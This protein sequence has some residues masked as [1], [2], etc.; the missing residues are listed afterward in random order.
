[1]LI[2]VIRCSN[3]K[4]SIRGNIIIMGREICM[5]NTNEKKIYRFIEQL[6]KIFS[7]LILALLGG[8][9][10]FFQSRVS[11]DGQTMEKVTFHNNSA[12][13][14]LFLVCII[15][16]LIFI[17]NRI[18]QLS[19][20][21]IYSVFAIIFVFFGIILALGVSTDLRADALEIYKS[22]KAF[23][24]GDFSALEQGNYVYHYPHQLGM[25]T[26]EWIMLKIVNNVEIL[27]LANLVF[28]LLNNY[29]LGQISGLLFDSQLAQNITLI[30]SF[31]F[32]PQFFFIVFAYGTIP[33]FSM[34]LLALYCQLRFLKEHRK[35]FF[36]LFIIF[37]CI[38]CLLK[39]N[40]L[41][42]VLAASAFF[43]FYA[44]KERKIRFIL[45]IIVTLSLVSL[46]GKILNWSY[47]N[48]SGQEVSGGEPK[49]LWIAMGLR[50]ESDKLGGWYDRYN[51]ETFEEVNYDEKAADLKAKESIKNSINRFANDLGYEF[52]YFKD[53]IETTWCDPLFQ[54]IWSG[55][56]EDC[57][58]TLND[59]SLK[60]IY[61]EGTIH[62][63]IRDYCTTFI[64]V[65]MG[66]KERNTGE[67]LT[68]IIF[69]IGGF[70]FHLFWETKSQYV[71]PYVFILIPYSS[72]TIVRILDKL[73]FIMGKRRKDDETSS[74]YSDTVL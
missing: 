17:R 74:L 66:F 16:S 51:W 25:I 4:N 64:F 24:S 10:F 48:I 59:Q 8:L 32:L 47:E 72:Y 39:N 55:P 71:Y 60:R 5:N 34:L 46:S 15:V 12:F 13:V 31:L 11:M 62:K 58:Q 40:Y 38:S 21:S 63:F 14:Y 54:S 22:V 29:V 7:I 20:K 73:N 61:S 65:I 37:S 57:G 30:L 67:L 27:F 68:G 69:L 9:S 2:F 52:D 43:A 3:I 19:P 56:L 18:K 23:S 53:K 50:D 35:K 36:V 70:I 44:L 42:G 1:M 49:T 41:I 6:V 33:G 28:A 45:Y 26:Y